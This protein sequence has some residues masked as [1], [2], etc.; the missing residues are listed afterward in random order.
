LIF[1]RRIINLNKD[2]IDL[3][4]DLG[5]IHPL[6][7]EN[8]D[9]MIM[10]FISSC[11]ICCGYHSS[12]ASIIEITIRNALRYGLKIG[13][14]PSYN[15]KESFGRK[16]IIQDHRITLADLRYQIA[17]LVGMT[18][19]IGSKVN[20]V[21][22]HG[23]LYHDIHSDLELSRKF[24]ELVKSFGRNIKILG[25]ANSPLSQLCSD[26]EIEFIHESFA[27]RRYDSKFELVSRL[28][29]NAVIHDEKEMLKQVN[30]FING[31]VEDVNGNSHSI[32]TD[33]IC[34]HSDTIGSVG[35]AKKINEYLRSINVRIA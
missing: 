32:N 33:T 27:D 14:H 18:E 6:T 13:A 34:L 15:D 16:S 8:L 25:M 2:Y 10:P 31:I 30:H 29:E 20:H 1:H 7:G 24:I 21:K 19:S 28:N 35:L 9:H 23:A 11:N 4:C 3:N 22:P 12:N 26:N 5:E 17:C